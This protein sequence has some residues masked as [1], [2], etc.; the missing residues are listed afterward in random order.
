VAKIMLEV[1][2]LRV[3][4]GHGKVWTNHYNVVEFNVSQ[5]QWSI[6]W[7]RRRCTVYTSVWSRI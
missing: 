6:Y 2:L 3:H 7:S 5:K 4:L 1:E